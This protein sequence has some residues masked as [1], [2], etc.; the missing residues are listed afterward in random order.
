MDKQ[1]KEPKNAAKR[2]VLFPK[3]EI[4]KSKEFKGYHQDILR[5]LL[6]KTSYTKEEARNIITKYF[7]GGE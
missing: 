3:E 2:P 6:P 7:K 5:A 1:I 4:I